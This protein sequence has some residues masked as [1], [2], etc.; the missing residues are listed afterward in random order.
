M[1][2]LI[3]YVLAL[4]LLLS[5]ATQPKIPLV[6]LSEGSRLVLLSPNALGRNLNVTQRATAQYRGADLEMLIMWEVSPSVV[7][8][9]ALTPFGSRLFSLVYRPP[10]LDFEVS[11]LLGEQVKPAYI[12]ADLMLCY[13]PVDTIRQQLQGDNLRLNEEAGVRRTLLQAQTEIVE[14]DYHGPDYPWRSK[15]VYR[16][17]KRHYSFTLQTLGMN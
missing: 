6:K 16:H 17:L 2:C 3:T 14:I 12:L 5:C 13:W 15:V 11:P 8:L 1:K 9:V 4:L 10:K 7:K